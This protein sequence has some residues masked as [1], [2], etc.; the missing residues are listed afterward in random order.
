VSQWLGHAHLETTQI[1]AH[2]D[3]EHKRT[4]IAKATPENSPLFSTLDPERLTTTDE[5]TLKRLTGLSN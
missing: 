3:T 4:A 2:A 1:Y 5:D